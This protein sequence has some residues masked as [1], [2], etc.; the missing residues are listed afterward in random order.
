M[1]PKGTRRTENEVQ[2]GKKRGLHFSTFLYYYSYDNKLIYHAPKLR[3]K[4]I[5]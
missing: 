4:L 3:P 5:I 1:Y 2:K